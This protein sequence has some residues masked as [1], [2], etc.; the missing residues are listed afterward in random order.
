MKKP[1]YSKPDFY[2]RKAKAQG[3][4]ARSVFKLSELDERFKILKPGIKVLDLG[5]APGSW[6]K[7]CAEKTG[8]AGK[9]VGIDRSSLN[10]QLRANE[11][12]I[13]SDVFMA[14]PAKLRGEFGAFDLV[15][16]DLAPDTTG[17]K[18]ADSARSIA[19]CERALKFAEHVLRPGGQFL[20]KVFQGEDFDGFMKTLRE[21][22]EAV[23][24]TKPQSSRPSS[25]EMYVYCSK[26]KGNRA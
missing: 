21:K 22:F 12:F 1:D 20:V 23:A 9:V 17:N 10:R 26:F 14:E 25:R 4:P 19:L 15:L 5:A 16:S 11:A 13:Q 7:Y 2:A 8:E 24:S 6:M 3:F 18:M